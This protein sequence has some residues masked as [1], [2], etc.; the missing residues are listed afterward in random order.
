MEKTVHRAWLRKPV[1]RE[2]L[3]LFREGLKRLFDRIDQGESEEHLKRIVA[4][5]LTEVW[6]RDVGEINTK[7]RADLVI[8]AGRS[9]RDPVAVIIET[10]HPANVTEMIS[11]AR[12]NAKALHELILYYLRERAAGNLGLTRLI[13]CN[14]YEWYIFDAA[15][16]DRY[17]YRDKGLIRQYRDWEANRLS[18]AR[19]DA[20]YGEIVRPFL[21]RSDIELT[22]THIDLRP[23]EALVRNPTAGGD[24]KLLP[25]FKLFSPPHLMKLP[26][27]NDSNTLNREFYNELLHIIGLEEIREKG[28]KLIGRKPEGKRDEGALLENAINVL[29]VRGCLPTVETI[30][31][32]VLGGGG[33]AKVAVT[34]AS[35]VT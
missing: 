10:K 2:A 4:D 25:L 9:S 6:Y 3:D 24:G 18:S 33:S 11:A 26:F 22:C 21:E 5:F 32:N 13:A 19:T 17:F 1:A 23:C 27:A 14:I 31:V 20:F 35:P 8:H 12:P 29:K 30:T 34:V 15:D 28:R 7:D 16:F